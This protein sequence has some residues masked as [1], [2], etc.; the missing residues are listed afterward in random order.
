MLSELIITKKGLAL[1]SKIT[2]NTLV[3]T[4]MGIGDGDKEISEDITRLENERIKKEIEFVEK[5]NNAIVARTTITNQ[6]L[7]EGF[8]IKEAGI[9]ALD[10]DEGEILYAYS[11]VNGT[12]ADYFSPGTGSVIL[13]EIIQLAI[14]FGNASK[15]ELII[16]PTSIYITASEFDNLKNIVETKSN[17]KHLIVNGEDLFE[18]IES[19]TDDQL[20]PNSTVTI[21]AFNCINSP[22]DGYPSV[23]DPALSNGG[24]FIIEVTRLENKD[25]YI[26]FA[27]EV[28]T[29]RTFRGHKFN[30]TWQPWLPIDNYFRL[31]NSTNILNFVLSEKLAN[32]D[33]VVYRLGN[34][35]G[36]PTNFGYSEADNDF[37]YVCYKTGNNYIKLEALDVRDNREFRNTCINGVWTG[38]VENVHTNSQG[39]ILARREQGG[40]QSSEGGQIA[41]EKPLTTNLANDVMVDIL[42]DAIRF[43]E[44]GGSYR[45]AYLSIT[46]CSANS[47]DKILTS[48]NV[49]VQSTAPTSPSVGDIW[50]W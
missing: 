27:E 11:S 3:L 18:F 33:R 35:K 31:P 5:Q 6:N 48:K 20:P 14:G 21:R 50:I 23:V 9:Y 41:L 47:G 17:K 16:D 12:E 19:L 26:L 37:Y 1:L 30:N 8:Y 32:D 2:T 15:V 4:N 22:I 29:H 36:V 10:P 44:G 34:G 7:E 43:F 13:R 45:G 28:T 42:N 40:T 39:H 24:D 25:W 49:A 46:N 38:W